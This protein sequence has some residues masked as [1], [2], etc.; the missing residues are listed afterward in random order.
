MEKIL[1]SRCLL[2]E[3]V[4]YDGND[5]LIPHPLITTWRDRW[6]PVC[7]E[8][9]G[10]LP[11]PRPPAELQQDGHIITIEGEDVSAAFNRGALHA[12]MLCKQHNIRFAVLKENSPSCG[13]HQIY[14]G[15]FSGVKVAGQGMTTQ[16]LLEAGI[17]V[18]SDQEL[19]A[20]ADAVSV[21]ESR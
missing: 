2:G 3:Q 8:V 19:D 1:I 7:P 6:V 18:F 15:T 12:L 14:D 9:S 5:N 11:T 17:Q 16:A 4:R 21:I 13:R 10:G 20:L